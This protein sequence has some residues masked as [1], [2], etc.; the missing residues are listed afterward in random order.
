[1]DEEQMSEK[2]MIS[3][4]IMTIAKVKG[5]YDVDQWDKNGENR[6]HKFFINEEKAKAEYDRWS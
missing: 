1:M 2:T 6:W 3:G 4:E 5:G